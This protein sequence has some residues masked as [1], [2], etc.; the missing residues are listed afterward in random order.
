MVKIKVI[1]EN[2][3]KTIRIPTDIRLLI[4]RCYHTALKLEG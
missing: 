1:I 2:Q 3:Q 4:R